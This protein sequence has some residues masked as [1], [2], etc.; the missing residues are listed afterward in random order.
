VNLDHADW[1]VAL[2]VLG[3]VFVLR[4]A[5]RWRSGRHRH[6]KVTFVVE[7]DYEGPDKEERVGPGPE[8]GTG[9]EPDP[10]QDESPPSP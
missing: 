5:L 9:P 8:V 7:R 4:T 1:V 6:F 2:G 3:V 10:D